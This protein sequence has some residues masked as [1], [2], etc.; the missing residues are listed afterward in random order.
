MI[1]QPLI[2]PDGQPW[3]MTEDDSLTSIFKRY[4]KP[5]EVA[6][7]IAFLLGDESKFVTKQ[8]LY[9][10]GGWMEANYVG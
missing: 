7:Y 3:T 8:E 1:K 9:V 6:A 10:D 5:E 4:A 2:L